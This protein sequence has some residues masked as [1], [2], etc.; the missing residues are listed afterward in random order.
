MKTLESKRVW[1]VLFIIICGCSLLFVACG[2]DDDEK[3]SENPFASRPL[4]GIPERVT[5][6][7][8]DNSIVL[9]WQ[10]GAKAVRYNIYRSTQQSEPPPYV[11]HDT[12]AQTT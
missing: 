7:M 3:E 8:K 12:T 4:P 2:N 10:A 6:Q 5:A 9:T 1:I 11:L